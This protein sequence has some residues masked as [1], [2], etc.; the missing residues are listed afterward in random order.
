VYER[1]HGTILREGWRMA[2]RRRHFTSI[3]QLRAEA[4]AWLVHYDNRRKNHGDLMRGRTPKH[5]LDSFN[6][7]KAA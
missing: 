6:Q 2:F 3:H 5:V 7:S 4:D 1:F